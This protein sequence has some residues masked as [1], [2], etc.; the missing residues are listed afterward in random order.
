MPRKFGYRRKRRNTRVKTTAAKALRVANYAKN[1]AKSERFY[2]DAT[3]NN[4]SISNAGTVTLLSNMAQGDD[5]GM[6]T[7]N[8]IRLRSLS[9]YYYAKGNA[10]NVA[11]AIRCILFI[12]KQNTGTTPTPADILQTTG[13]V[14]SII[15][16]INVDHTSRYRVIYDRRHVFTHQT[17]YTAASAA[18]SGVGATIR[19]LYK[20]MFMPVKW[21]GP[22][23][24]DTYTN[25]VYLLLLSDVAANDPD[26]SWSVRLG[27]DDH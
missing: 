16:H 10:Q 11:N 4:Q 6:R 12:D 7:G 15:S 18:S 8:S 19:T 3:A 26:V 20:K 13:S 22:A 2:Y 1:L 25:A 9:F 17:N 21:T 24:T 5:D 27:Y 14:G 23:G